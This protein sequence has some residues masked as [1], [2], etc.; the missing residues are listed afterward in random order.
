MCRYRPSERC[1]PTSPGLACK[2]IHIRLSYG[3]R[4]H[5]QRNII[6][7]HGYGGVKLQECHEYRICVYGGKHPSSPSKDHKRMPSICVYYPNRMARILPWCES[8][9]TCVSHAWPTSSSP[10]TTSCMCTGTSESIA[11]CEESNLI[12]DQ[13]DNLILSMPMPCTDCI[14]SHW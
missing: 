7:L 6:E 14:S 3:E 12:Q 11:C 8:G 13:L 4:H 1:L 9:T 5:L 2:L 10:S